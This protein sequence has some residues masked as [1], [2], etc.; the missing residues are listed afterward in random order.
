MPLTIFYTGESKAMQGD[1][2]STGIFDV[3]EP[4]TPQTPDVIINRILN[5]DVG[6]S[7]TDT[8]KEAR[9]VMNRQQLINLTD[10]SYLAFSL[11]VLITCQL[12]P[13]RCCLE[14]QSFASVEKEQAG[15]HEGVHS[16]VSWDVIV[17]PWHLAGE[18][19][20]HIFCKQNLDIFLPCDTWPLRPQCSAESLPARK[21]QIQPLMVDLPKLFTVYKPPNLCDVEPRKTRP[22]YRP[23]GTNLHYVQ[24]YHRPKGTYL[25]YV[26]AYHRPKG[27]YLHYV[28]AYHRPKVMDNQLWTRNS[29]TVHVF[30]STTT[31]LH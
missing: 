10:V 21:P 17:K 4:Q 6:F 27:T 2:I 30:L 19:Q 18:P 8:R 15:Q 31:T 20:Y 14:L 12:F 11:G 24:A 16:G 26:Q 29:K 7:H 22:Q 13:Q 3:P 5:P 25:H 1:I 9:C 23:K 28:Q